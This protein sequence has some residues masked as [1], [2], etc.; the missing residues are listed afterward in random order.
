MSGNTAT[1]TI[2]PS[3]QPATPSGAVCNAAP[4]Q[5]MVGR[6]AS[7]SVVEDARQKSGALMA[8]VLRPDQVVT[9]EFNAQ[10]LNLS[11]DAAGKVIRVNCG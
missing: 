10:R 7:A 8:R 3:S 2:S 4:V 9:M 11:V 1:T 6:V 5:S